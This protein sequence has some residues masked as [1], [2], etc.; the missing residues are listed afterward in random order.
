M[1]RVQ[2]FAL[3]DQHPNPLDEPVFRHISL[4]QLLKQTIFL[5]LPVAFYA[6]SCLRALSLFLLWFL[7]S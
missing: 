3:S 5:H 6:Q 2:P 4:G 1:R 7:S